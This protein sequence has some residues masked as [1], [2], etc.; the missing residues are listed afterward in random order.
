MTETKTFAVITLG[1]KLNY[2][3]SATI[4]RDFLRQ[5]YERV[6]PSKKADVYLINT[7]SV[8]EH[9]DKKSRQAIRKVLRINPSAYVVVTGC[10]AQLR[11]ETLGSIPGVCALFGTG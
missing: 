4:A 8:T 5:G 9:A 2:A 1:C 11:P 10:S 6:N 7:C 3:E